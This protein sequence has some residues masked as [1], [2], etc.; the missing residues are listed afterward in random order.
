MEV[1]F[2]PARVRKNKK[3]GYTVVTPEGVT[4]KNT[5]RIKA[6]RQKRLIN[7]VRHGWKPTGKR[8]KK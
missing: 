1:F 4:A 6:E 8:R 3:G 7:A 5:T 2:V